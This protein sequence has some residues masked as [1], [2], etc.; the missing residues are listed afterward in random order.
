ME[1]QRLPGKIV[2]QA[3]VN[4]SLNRVGIQLQPKQARLG[5]WNS[6]QTGARKKSWEHSAGINQMQ[7]PRRVEDLYF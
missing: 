7:E 4:N 5:S 2:N 1:M 3:P 6:T